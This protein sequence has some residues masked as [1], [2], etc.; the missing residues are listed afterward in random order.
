M[1]IA[2]D[3]MD[4]LVLVGGDDLHPGSYGDDH[5]GRSKGVERQGRRVGDRPRPGSS[6]AGCPCSASVAAS[7]CST[8]PSAA[9]CTR[10]SWGPAST[11]RSATSPTRCSGAPSDP[12]PARMPAGRCLRRDGPSGREHDPPP[13]HRS[14]RPGWARPPGP[15]TASSKRSSPTTRPCPSSPCSSTRRRSAPRATRCCS[16]GSCGSWSCRQRVA[17]ERGVIGIL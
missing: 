13:S 7:R 15:M 17:N 3:G 12:H 6:A 5:D 1:P 4:G 11:A 14:R 2:L 16:T 8:S 9:P 10:T